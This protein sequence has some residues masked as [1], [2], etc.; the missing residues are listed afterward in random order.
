V[1]LAD[2]VAVEVARVRQAAVATSDPHLLDV[3]AAE[4]VDVAPLP[5]TTG[6]R[7]SPP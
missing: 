6:T 2:C 5:D 4:D 3:C 1:S 7:W